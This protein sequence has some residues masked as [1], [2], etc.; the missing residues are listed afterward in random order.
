MR[1]ESTADLM[2]GDI[3]FSSIKGC[4]GA[5]ILLGQSLIDAAALLRGKRVDTAGWVTHAYVV[6]EV[7]SMGARIVEAMP[8]GA[9]VEWL[10]RRMRVGPGFGYARLP[11][12]E[13][14]RAEI[15]AYAP[16]LRGT[17]YSFADYASLA[18]LHVGVRPRWL[19]DYVAGTGHMICSQLVDHTYSRAGVR[20]FLD[21]R[22]S[23]DVTPGALFW[24]AASLGEV[25]VW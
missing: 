3:G 14:Q 15:A 25:V 4:V 8:G 19:R 18:A 17:P 1:I 6:T 13:V 5:G 23:Q 22:P 7:H 24:R 11:I 21:G 12:S 2:P 20:L 16:T 10:T 9:R